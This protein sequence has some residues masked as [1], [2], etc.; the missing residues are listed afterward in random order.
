MSRLTR[1]TRAHNALRNVGYDGPADLETM[2]GFCTHVPSGAARN[3]LTVN[4]AKVEKGLKYGYLNAVCYLAPAREAGLGLTVCPWAGACEG[5]CLRDTGRMRFPE[6]HKARVCRTVWWYLARPSFI[7]RVEFE[8]RRLERKA[9]RENLE[10]VV[11]MDGTSDLP[12]HKW[13]GMAAFPKVKFNDYTKGPV[14]ADLP[15]N[16]RKIY[17]LSE[18]PTSAQYAF[19]TLRAGGTVA[20]VVAG[21]TD[22]LRDA[23]DVQRKILD[24]GSLWGFPVVDGD[25]H[26]IRAIDPKG[27]IVIL[28]AKGGALTDRSGFVKREVKHTDAPDAPAMPYGFNSGGAPLVQIAA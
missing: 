11:R 1:L 18:G 2:L 23:R 22:R 20:V 7:T 5:P 12:W 24:R 26:D 9:Q 6:A 8:I 13:I 21:T 27:V 17:S 15:S 25:A 16:Y 28:H 3:I 14:S 10:V 4:S 19:E